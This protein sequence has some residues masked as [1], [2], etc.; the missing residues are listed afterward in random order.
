MLY[1]KSLGRFLFLFILSYQN[2]NLIEQF[3]MRPCCF[4]LL[5]FFALCRFFQSHFSIY[6]WNTIK[7]SSF[8]L[9][10]IQVVWEDGITHYGIQSKYLQLHMIPWFYEKPLR[11]SVTT[12]FFIPFYIHI[13]AQGYCYLNFYYFLFISVYLQKS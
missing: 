4:R 3:K 1:W 5:H 13:C 11:R 10:V 9:M 12:S 6:T 7:L 2:Q 8:F